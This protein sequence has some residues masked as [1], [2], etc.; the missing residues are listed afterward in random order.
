MPEM[1][2]RILLVTLHQTAGVVPGVKARNT[3]GMA[4]TTV[5]GNLAKDPVIKEVGESRVANFSIPVNVSKDETIW[6]EVAVWGKAADFVEQYFKKG[7]G[8]VV[9]GRL[10][11]RTWEKNGKTN[12]QMTLTA[13]GYPSFGTDRRASKEDE[14]TPF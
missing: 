1:Q 13:D 11:Y 5:V 12:V 10:K 2:V 14:E 6:Y 7:T 4:V 8:I 3:M 9:T